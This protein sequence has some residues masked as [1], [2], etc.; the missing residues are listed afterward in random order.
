MATIVSRIVK[1]SP[2]TNIEADANFA[3]LNNDKAETLSPTFTGVPLAPTASTNNDSTQIATTA[4]V[5]AQGYL[6]ASSAPVLTVAGKTGNVVLFHYDVTGAAPTASPT[7]TGVPVAPTASAATNTDQIATTSFVKAQ[8][9]VTA[10]GVPVLSVAGK[11]GAVTLV[12]ADVGLNVVDNTTD[13][14][15]PISTA[16]SNALNLKAPLASPTFTGTVTLPNGNTAVDFPVGTRILFHQSTAPTGYV[17]DTSATLNDCALRVVTGTVS[18][19]GTT[20]FST[21]FAQTVTGGTVLTI[22]QMPAHTHGQSGAIGGPGGGAGGVGTTN[23]TSSTGGGL[24]HNHPLTINVK[25][26]DVIIASKS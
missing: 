26:H 23:N 10:A 7:F 3:N 19:G 16:T 12:K 5:K 22:A 25:Y 21:V 2:L 1:G 14:S 15:K 18:S 24:T 9:Y 6:L 17:K 11:V 4:F 20:A 13:L 8:G